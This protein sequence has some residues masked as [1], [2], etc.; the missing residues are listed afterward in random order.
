M[1]QGAYLCVRTLTW[2]LN[3]SSKGVLWDIT[4]FLHSLHLSVQCL[5]GSSYKEVSGH[6][7]VLKVF[8]KVCK[9]DHSS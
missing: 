5:N 9:F 1:L 7:A 4:F 3:L 8:P 2:L 6:S